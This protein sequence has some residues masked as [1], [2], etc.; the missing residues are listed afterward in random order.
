MSLTLSLYGAAGTVTGSRFL[1]EHDRHRVLVDCGLFQGYK[2]LRERNWAP[3]PFS[4]KSLDAVVLTHAHIDHSGA[5]PLLTR[6]GFSGK[7]HATAGTKALCEILL[8]DSA[9]IHEAD[10]EYANRK[11]FSRHRPALPLYTERDARDTLGQFV[12]ERFGVPFEPARGF[13]ISYSRAGHILGAA[14]ALIKA[15]DTT[16]MF[17][18]DLGRPNDLLIREPANR[19]PT[20]YVVIEATY[21]GRKHSGADPAAALADII[22]RTAKRGGKL[23]IP[24]FSVGRTQQILLLLGQLLDED[25]IPRLPIYMDSPMAISATELYRRHPATHRLS[26]AACVRMG[27]VAQYVREVDDSKA[28]DHRDDPIILISASGMATGGRVVHHLGWLVDDPRNTVLF[29]GFQAAGTRGA[30]LVDGCDRIRI[31]G[32]WHDVRAEVDNLDMLSAHADEDELIGWLRSCEQAP[33]KVFVV[34]AEPDA[35]E[36]MRVRIDDELGWDV[37][38][39]EHKDVIDL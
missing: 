2:Q 7:I 11:G 34:H 19:Q 21:G 17:S 13:Q 9:R 39:P 28:L 6:A 12:I 38:V 36:A 1:L 31:H 4:A 25:R 30:K 8:P 16:V 22:T 33:R 37:V 3:L 23:L 29:T 18:G 20:D 24:A 14:S 35:A 5:L 26:A 27:E 10:A 15:G 32:Q